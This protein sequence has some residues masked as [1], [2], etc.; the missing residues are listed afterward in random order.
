M[1]EMRMQQGIGYLANPRANTD[2]KYFNIIPYDNVNQIS[3]GQL[4]DFNQNGDRGQATYPAEDHARIHTP[5]IP[6]FYQIPKYKPCKLTIEQ[7][8]ERY[9][10]SGM[11]SLLSDDLFPFVSPTLQSLYQLMPIRNMFLQHLC[12]KEYCLSCEINFQFRLMSMRGGSGIADVKNFIRTFQS[13]QAYSEIKSL[14]GTL[15]EEICSFIEN[16]F[17]IIG[18]EL[19]LTITSSQAKERQITKARV[20]GKIENPRQAVVK[21]DYSAWKEGTK[22]GQLVDLINPI[23][24][25]SDVLVVLPAITPVHTKK[26]QSLFVRQSFWNFIDCK[27]LHDCTNLNCRYKHPNNKER[28]FEE[29]LGE[30]NFDEITMPANM[31]VGN[32]SYTLESAIFV[33]GNGELDPATYATHA[34]SIAKDITKM[35]EDNMNWVI[36]SQHATGITTKPEAF[37]CNLS[38]KMPVALFY[39]K[40]K[41]ENVN[42]TEHKVEIPLDIFWCFDNLAAGQGNVNTSNDSK[43]PTNNNN[44]HTDIFKELREGK[45]VALDA[46]FISIDSNDVIKKDEI[47][48]MSVVDEKG[49]V[50]IDDYVIGGVNPVFDYKTAVNPIQISDTVKICKLPNKP[51]LSLQ[52]LALKMLDKKVQVDS[53]DSIVDAKT[54]LEIYNKAE[55]MIAEGT[56]E[57]LL[58]SV[59]E[60]GMHEWECE[61]YYRATP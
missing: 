22:L 48:R 9:N 14:E 4:N 50:L 55:E 20:F 7:D 33:I 11:V 31:R 16:L 47:G 37:S 53:H 60:L 10:K 24:K 28:A 32:Q 29:G 40:S 2:M 39:V 36:F 13:F 54:A 17:T 45:V 43:E 44:K 59:Y 18:K 6:W 38:W 61:R 41:R 34:I 42:M 58:K 8:I 3:I 23:A 27:Y 57:D 35:S 5:S 26:V 19:D 25:E 46:E 12:T 52:K 1:T 49:E 15:R 30:L 56:L 21:L 51:M